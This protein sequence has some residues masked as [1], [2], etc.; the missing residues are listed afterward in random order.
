MQTL[1]KQNNRYFELRQSATTMQMRLLGNWTILSMAE[2]EEALT[3]EKLLTKNKFPKLDMNCEELGE[4]DTS[5]ALLL[6]KVK[7]SHG[8]SISKLKESFGPLLVRVEESKAQ[9]AAPAVKT[10]FVKEQLT[11]IGEKTIAFLQDSKLLLSFF[12]EMLVLLFASI[13]K[14]F[15]IRAASLSHHMKIM[16]F[17][18]L[19]IIGLLNFL[20]GIVIAYQGAGQLQKFGAEIYTVNLVGIGTLREMGILL[21]AIIL[22]GRTGSSI[23]AQIGTMAVNEEIDALKTM[24]VNPYEI[25][26]VPRLLALILVFPLLTFFADILALIGGMIG[27]YILLDINADQFIAQIHEAVPL[28][29]FWVGMMKAPVFAFIIALVGCFE[30]LKVK[31]SAESVGIHTTS[32]VVK[33]IFIIIVFDAIFSVVLVYFDI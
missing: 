25:L 16:G 28:M 27:C 7:H 26:V 4:L 14:P 21:T 12:G 23:T 10:S 33:S 30:G 11:E 9:K 17:D 3:A 18:S 29:A 15:H 1:K 31:G 22:A 6:L 2:I 20:V 8:A 13:L 32:S 19:P 24:G 5:G